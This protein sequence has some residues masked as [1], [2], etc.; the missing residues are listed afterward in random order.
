ML[1]SAS[2]TRDVFMYL[3]MDSRSLTKQSCRKIPSG[4]LMNYQIHRSFQVALP[5]RP[6]VLAAES[7]ILYFRG[8]Q[9]G[10]RLEIYPSAKWLKG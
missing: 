9:N 10:R 5:S 7:K 1:E 3:R 2:Q 6:R 8:T 4:E